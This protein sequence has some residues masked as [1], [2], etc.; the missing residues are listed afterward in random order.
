MRAGIEKVNSAMR[1]MK[2]I[3][4]EPTRLNLRCASI[5][6]C[7][8]IWS[9]TISARADVIIRGRYVNCDYEYLVDI[10]IGLVAHGDSPPS[11]NHGFGVNLIHSASD[12]PLPDV[13]NLRRY[14]YIDASYDS[15]EQRLPE[16]V[17]GEDIREIRRDFPSASM[18][19]KHVRFGGVSAVRYKIEYANYIQESAVAMRRGVTFLVRL[20]TT[21]TAYVRDLSTFEGILRGT[22]L[23]RFRV[24]KECADD[25]KR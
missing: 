25:A 16:V 4:I 13:A 6:G 18:V 22:D 5:A 9:A 10:P 20:K 11:P 8:F 23:D 1:F 15:L 14:L 7:F 17:A 19:L 12:A 2:S 24:R 3:S 21:R